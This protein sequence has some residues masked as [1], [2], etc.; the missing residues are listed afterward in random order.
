MQNPFKMGYEGVKAAID[1]IHG[2]PVEKRIDTGVTVV[3]MDNF[4]DP[5][6]R[7]CSSPSDP[8]MTNPP[9]SI[10]I[11]AFNQCGYCEACVAS[12]RLHTPNPTTSSSSTT[13]PP[14]ACPP[15]SMPSPAPPSS[16]APSISASPAA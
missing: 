2:K 16:T 13:A 3:T 12:L 1:A 9:V 8:A 7:N 11:P 14:T 15:S 6:S 10:I 5:R 4:N